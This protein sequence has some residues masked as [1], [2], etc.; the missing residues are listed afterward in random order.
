MKEIIIIG[1]LHHEFTPKAELEEIIKGINPDKVLVELSPEE[2]LRPRED[3]IRDEMFFAHDWAV[4][5]GKQVD[6]FDIENHT[7][8]DGFTGREVGLIQ[9]GSEMGE[10]LKVHS[11][12]EQNSENAWKTPEYTK[13]NDLIME[14]YFNSEKLEERNQTM[15]QN[16]KD[17]VIEG[18]NL[19]IAGTAHLT[20]FK[21]QLPNAILP[22]RK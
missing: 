18:K 19:V 20:F 6:V 1:T 7:L 3:S 17:K 13:V 4:E 8:K 21:E 11:W 14:K 2:L 22:L 9:L 16:I 12:K 15:L 10:L 5:N